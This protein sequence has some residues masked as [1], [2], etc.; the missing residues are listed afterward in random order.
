MLSAG[1]LGVVTAGVGRSGACTGRSG[2]RAALHIGAAARAR[3]GRA[4]I[5]VRRSSAAW[6]GAKRLGGCG[7]P[8]ERGLAADL[9]VAIAAHLAGLPATLAARAV[10]AKLARGRVAVARLGA[11]GGTRRVVWI[12]AQACRRE[13]RFADLQRRTADLVAPGIAVCRLGARL[14][15]LVCRQTEGLVVD[16]A[17]HL[18]RGTLRIRAAL[19]DARGGSR[20]DLG[21][22]RDILKNAGLT[23]GCIATSIRRACDWTARRGHAGFA[24]GAVIAA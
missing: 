6:P 10:T 11:S 9:P 5:V 2:S 18:A 3:E 23:V 12:D 8:R 4:G 15:A 24:C 7:Q 14:W 22:G 21:L 17:A 19:G 1:S 16:R 13:V 20:A